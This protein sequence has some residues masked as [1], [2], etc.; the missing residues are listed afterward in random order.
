LP[1]SIPSFSLL[2]EVWRE[3]IE[4]HPQWYP[5]IQPG[6]DKLQDYEDDLPQTPAYIIAMGMLQMHLLSHQTDLYKPLIQEINLIF[7]IACQVP[8]MS[9]LRVFSLK[10]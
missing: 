1:Y 7:I 8:S 6:L 4:I 2:I 10:L 5:L 9:G 3:L